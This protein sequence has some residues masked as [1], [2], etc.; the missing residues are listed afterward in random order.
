MEKIRRKKVTMEDVAKNAGVSVTTV[1]HV[2]NQTA[3]ISEETVL[4]VREAMA[5]LGYVPRTS[6][7]LNCGQRLIAVFI[8]D[9]SNEFYAQS[10]QA[11]FD[12]AWQHD[13][14]VMSRSA[15]TSSS[16]DTPP[17]ATR[18]REYRSESVL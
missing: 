2:V 17:E 16:A 8:P 7:A 3:S 1:S 4:R 9:I 18:S 13:Y 11:I 6:A 5:S 14:A 15:R 10:V 12:E